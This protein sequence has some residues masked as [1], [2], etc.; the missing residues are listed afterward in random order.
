MI[1]L[2]LLGLIWNTIFYHPIVNLIVLS[3]KFTGNLGFSIIVITIIVRLVLWPLMKSQIDSLKKMQSMKPKLDALRKKYKNDKKKF[4]EEQLKLYRVSGVNPAGSCLPL[5]LQIPF[6]YS[7]YNVIRAVSLSKNTS[8]FNN[9]VYSHALQLSSKTKF[10]MNFF[11]INL[12]KDAAG[13]GFSHFNA[14][15][16]YLILALLVGITQYFASKVSMPVNTAELTETVDI[17]ENPKK[18]KNAKTIEK[19]A[20]KAKDEPLDPEQFSKMVSSQML[21]FFPLILV[22]ISLGYSGSIP[23]ALSIYWIVQS[24]MVVLQTLILQDK[25]P[26]KRKK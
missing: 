7:V 3:Y 2:S 1:I 6:I 17:I 21:Y 8:V 15:L 16:P 4:Q 12:A 18:K 5:L 11:G 24:L 20:P 26:W 22:W 19:N 23:A 10:N 13:V 14:V 9:V 25:I